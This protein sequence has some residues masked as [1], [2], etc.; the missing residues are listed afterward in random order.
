MI[1]VFIFKTNDVE[2]IKSCPIY[3]NDGSETF[4][5]KEI[6]K[7]IGFGKRPAFVCRYLKKDDET[8]IIV[9]P[10]VYDIFF[11][12]KNGVVEISFEELKAVFD[13]IKTTCSE[14]NVSI[15]DNEDVNV[16]IHPNINQDGGSET[17]IATLYRKASAILNGPR[18]QFKLY[19]IS[20]GHQIPESIYPKREEGGKLKEI[21][22][23]EISRLIKTLKEK[24]DKI[25]KNDTV[26]SC[27]EYEIFPG[28]LCI[29]KIIIDAENNTKTEALKPLLESIKNDKRFSAECAGV[30]GKAVENALENL[31]NSMS[32]DRAEQLRSALY[33]FFNVS[34]NEKQTE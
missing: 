5:K 6:I 14:A 18:A 2:E 29:C 11:Q 32:R 22:I 1:A 13:K 34:E 16:F 9:N 23:P 24:Y 4:G 21:N 12:T 30:K 25:L 20:K 27:H 8:I 19:P 33:P 10:A 3:Y 31:I 17:N 15:G 7:K 28:L 26:L